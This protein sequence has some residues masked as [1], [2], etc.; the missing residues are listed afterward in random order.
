MYT[1]D[2]VCVS[3]LY[4]HEVNEKSYNDKFYFALNKYKQ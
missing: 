3:K 4:N 1:N 2:Y